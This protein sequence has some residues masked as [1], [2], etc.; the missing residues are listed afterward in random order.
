[1]SAE[2]RGSREID[3]GLMKLIQRCRNIALHF[4]VNEDAELRLPVNGLIG[5]L[6]QYEA[7]SDRE[8]VDERMVDACLYGG[9][10]D[11]LAV[12]RK[13]CEGPP[14]DRTILRQCDTD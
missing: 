12:L 6:V 9:W 1:M 5:L 4:D 11:E 14:P 8:L 3:I 7:R 2:A 13:N 10:L